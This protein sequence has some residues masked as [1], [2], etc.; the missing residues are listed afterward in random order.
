MND[1]SNSNHLHQYPMVSSQNILREN[2]D[3]KDGP[4][5]VVV[6]SN[7]RSGGYDVYTRV[8]Q[9]MDNTDAS[10]N[11][12][13]KGNVFGN[14]LNA[15]IF[16][17]VVAILLVVVGVVGG[18]K[19]YLRHKHRLQGGQKSKSQME[20]IGD[21]SDED[22]EDGHITRNSISVVNAGNGLNG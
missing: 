14:K 7:T 21:E 3:Y 22:D 16:G 15:A 20:Q 5:F 12:D 9:H 4:E 10:N 6:W 13:G 8:I 18:R 17:I 19:L 1:D 11:D 2:E